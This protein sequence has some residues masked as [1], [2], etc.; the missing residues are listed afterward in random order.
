[1]SAKENGEGSGDKHR[2]QGGNRHILSA[3]RCEWFVLA[4][5]SVTSV[6]P[7]CLFTRLSFA[8][9]SRTHW[10]LSRR[11]LGTSQTPTEPLRSFCEPPR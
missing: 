3:H 4:V 7:C 8:T 2:T 10:H 1:M 6:T 11:R 9:C 5:T